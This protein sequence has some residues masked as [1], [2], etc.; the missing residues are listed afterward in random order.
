MSKRFLLALLLLI[1]IPASAQN[2]GLAIVQGEVKDDTGSPIPGVTITAIRNETNAVAVSESDGAFRIEHLQPGAYTLEAILDGFQPVKTQVRLTTGQK[3]DVAFKMVPAF[4]ETVD[5][6]ADA[7]KTGE[8]AILE[9]RRQAAVVSDSISAE[10]IKKTPDSS[11]AGVVERL[12][13]VTLLGDK[14]VF[15]RGLGERY[16][17]TTINGST[18][19]T[20]ETEKRVVPLDLFPS[21]LLDSVNVVKTYTP[22]KAGDF[23]SGVVEM[24]TTQFPG[25]QTL[26][27]TL[28]SSYQSGTTGDDFRVYSSQPLPSSMPKEFLQ[29]QSIL[30]PNGLSPAQLETIGESLVGDW[31]GRQTSASPSTD[32]ALT[33]GNTFG[34]LGVVLSGVSNHGYNATDEI[35]R[36][37]GV[38]G[39]Q[40]VAFNDYNLTSNKET[41]SA[42]AVGNVSLRLTD[43]H[44]L[45]LSSVLTRDASSE[46]RYQEG[47]QT[48]SGGDIRDYRVRYQ[49]EQILSTRLRG[50]HNLDGPGIG[51]LIEWSLA[52]S[53]A[54]N[55]SDLRENLY[56]ESSP[57]VFE[58]QTGFAD[59]GK[60]EYFNLD[61]EVRQGGVTYS[62]FFAPASGKWSGTLKGGV[63][64][65]ERTRD[66][67]ARRFRF[68]TS[69]HMQFD[70]TRSPDE[71]YTAANIRPDGFEIRETTGVN[72]AYDA[73]HTVDAAFVMSDMTIG[74][75]RIIGGA[76]YE[77]SNQRV[78]TFNP[79]DVESSVDSI[80]D[81]KDVLPSLNVVYQLGSQT[82]LR[83][84]YGR[85][86][87][88][89]EFRELSP[90]T[91]TEVAGGRSVAGNPDL[92]QATLDSYD[93]RWETFP[94]S[95][96]VIAASLFYKSIA[97]PIE[98]I[99]QPTTDLRQSF[100]NADSAK[101]YGLE[102]EL[103]R[104]L[105]RLWSVNANYAHIK[106]DVEIGEQ[107]FSV[108]TSTDRPLEG[109]SD[110]VGNLALQFYHPQWG[111]M[112]RILGSYSGPRLTEVGS[113]GLPD[114]YESAYTSFDVVV[115]QSVGAIEI[116]LAGS[117]LTDEKR[118]F[119]QGGQIQRSFDP[120]RKFSL[121]L[122]FTP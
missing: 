13:G 72:D 62:L 34:R 9:S 12:T 65:N 30:N 14:Y 113:F 46:D 101:L 122:S 10:E 110:N 36:F 87:N 86:V 29:R 40:L 78:T 59:S 4:G 60:L 77:D 26:K 41:A 98:R 119:T 90:F 3:L 109:Q 82:N 23:G 63:D 55:D 8:V 53:N 67:A 43:Q 116:K 24:T 25:S 100:V 42:G 97:H 16:S 45:Y 1:A 75:W 93:M 96:E 106:S 68:V 104:A 56:R 54:S 73:E 88:R 37:F 76:R 50:E 74:Q 18:V 15:V 85:S 83:F 32:L 5:V 47:L 99:V 118:E 38:D 81:D 69:N 11:A 111:T 117:N 39:D 21:K 114:I 61:D 102:L 58:M 17:G 33:Y 48:N 92:E 64:R 115:S 7:V 20:T 66:F 35:Q 91:F 103:R 27:V 94:R 80:H 89:P 49:L 108:V 44:R 95:G 6:V 70:L 71:I 84:A 79:F 28:G 57:G 22:D 112:F 2:S 107:Q 121:S 19:P 105:T 120:G 51:S 31:T 52:R